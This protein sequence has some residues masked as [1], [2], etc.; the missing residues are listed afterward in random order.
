MTA[1]EPG[2]FVLVPYPLDRPDSAQKRPALVISSAGYNQSTGDLVIAQVTGRLSAPQRIGDS[3]IF[4]WQEVNLASTSLIRSRLATVKAAN[5]IRRLG[6]LNSDD[7]QAVLQSLNSS[8]F[9]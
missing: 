7:F 8:I 5:V 6:Q 2:D 4:N 9:E 1:Y 3:P